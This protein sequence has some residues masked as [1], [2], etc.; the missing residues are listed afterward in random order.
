MRLVL[1]I[2]TSRARRPLSAG[3]GFPVPGGRRDGDELVP[4]DT[5]HSDGRKRQT[6]TIER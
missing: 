4:H 1:W 3:F 5:D 2:L 6:P